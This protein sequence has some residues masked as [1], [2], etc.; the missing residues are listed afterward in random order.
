MF[1][2][3]HYKQCILVRKR[4]LLFKDNLH[5]KKILGRKVK[6]GS[7]KQ[8][9]VYT[10]GK[11]LLR[12]PFD[13]IP[14]STLNH[15][16]ST[17]K[18][19]NLWHA[20]MGRCNSNLTLHIFLHSRATFVLE[21]PFQPLASQRQSDD[22]RPENVCLNRVLCTSNFL[23]SDPFVTKRASCS[24]LHFLLTIVFRKL[25]LF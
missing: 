22:V 19:T 18:I 3:S 24:R 11:I 17:M 25:F 6:A 4:L 20:K 1:H 14:V 2:C 8:I 23:K 15:K 21:M 16:L 9:E 10:V 7:K 5:R 12:K 13:D